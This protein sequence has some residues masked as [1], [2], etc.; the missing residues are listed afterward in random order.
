MAEPRFVSVVIPNRNGANVIGRCLS[1]ALASKHQRFEVVVVDDASTDRSVEIVEQFPCTLVRL[2]QHGGVSKA[3]NAGAQ[4]ARGDLLFFI[5]SDCLLQA[6]SIALADAS[7][8]GGVL[9]GTYTPLPADSDFFSA[10]QS[11]FIHHHETRCAEPDYVAAHA[12]VIDAELFRRS[13]GFIEGSF[14][15]EAASVEDVELCHRLRRA[16][17]ELRMNPELQ[18]THI[19]RFS[20][21]R[22]LRNAVKKA[23]Y[24]TMYSLVNGDL[25]ADSGAAALRLKLTVALLP[26]LPLTLFINLPLI[27][28]FRAAK[29]SWFATKAAAYY[30]TLYPLAVAAGGMLGA[31]RYLRLDKRCTTRCG[32]SS[33]ASPST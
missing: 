24:W 23:S 4:A 7:Y 8:T 31:L 12:M 28:A 18:V 16:G 33:P 3:R 2:Q 11:I 13:G 26:L 32:I 21:L 27:R 14:I 5:D 1:A 20:L 10:F 19:F 30:L 25:L 22:S 29:G 17:V 6:D 9:G 15:G